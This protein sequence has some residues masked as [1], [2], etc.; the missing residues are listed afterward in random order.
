VA[1]VAGV[2]VGTITGLADGLSIAVIVGIGVSLRRGGGA[3][4]RHAVL[5]RLLVRAGAAPADYVAFLDHAC[6]LIL[7]RRRGDGYEF[8]HRLLLDHFADLRA[9]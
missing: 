6:D 1:R 8:V 4:L 2:A 9:R 3:Y 5:R 7:L